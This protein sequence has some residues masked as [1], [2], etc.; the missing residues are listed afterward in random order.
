MHRHQHVHLHGARQNPWRD[1]W[2]SMTKAVGDAFHPKNPPQPPQPQ[3]PST[4]TVYMT[5]TPEGFKGQLTTVPPAKE[6]P[7]AQ[8]QAQV[9]TSSASDAKP[10]TNIAAKAVAQSSSRAGDTLAT[11]GPLPQSIVPT[12]SPTNVS[13][14]L[15]VDTNAPTQTQRQQAGTPLNLPATATPSAAAS[16]GGSDSTAAKAGIALGVL[17][18]IAFI[19]LA[20]FFVFK[21][22]R[23]SM[24]KRRAADD[25]KLNG[26]HGPF[27]DQHAIPDGAAAAAAGGSYPDRR[28]SRGANIAMVQSPGMSNRGGGASAWERRP[29]ESADPA[30]PFGDSAERLHTPTAARQN[31]A[32]PPVPTESTTAAS[33][34]SPIGTAMAGVVA[35]AAAGAAAGGMKRKASIR[36]DAPKALDLTLPPTLSAVPPSP[37]GTEFSM[38]MVSP[39]QPAAP[40]ASAAAIAAA[41]G[42]PSSTVHR[43]QL[44]FK[45]T[46]EDE[47][48]LKAGQLI[49]L[50]HE[51]DDGWALC[52]RLDRSQQGVVPRTCLSTRPVKPRPHGPGPRPGPPVNPQRG[53]GPNYP[54]PGQRPMTPQGGGPGY[55][56]PQSPAGR[57]G[58]QPPQHPPPQ[59][60]YGPG[61]GGP[62]SQSPGPRAQSPGPRY[63]HQQQGRPQSP[64]PRAQ[65]PGPRYQQ[66]QQGR[67]QSPMGNRRH[68]PPSHHGPSPM[69]QEYR[70]GPPAAS[71]SPIERRPVPGQA[72]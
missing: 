6:T 52:I 68:S 59:S 5:K 15:A 34:T 53:P 57:P 8:A 33:P 17:G 67:P 62:R 20:V 4:K 10:T 32:L 22:R 50:L 36:K 69:N 18:G 3:A 64:G 29:S 26:G 45:A 51:Y 47:M 39:D 14:Q 24:D 28:A 19:I 38:T 23:S 55:P 12:Q 70:P 16:S 31:A 35:G 54:P 30:N 49:R 41:G 1:G 9:G 63:H 56:R 2:D 27:G 43:V 72:Y 13:G 61:P 44:D 60:P 40:S 58:H 21:K 48:D 7:K 11:D 71:G 37:A 42:P 66:Q 46:L 65:S 25:E